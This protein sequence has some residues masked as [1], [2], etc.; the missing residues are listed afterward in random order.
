MIKKQILATVITTMMLG[1]TMGA[2]ARPIN[3]VPLDE[4]MH[5]VQ[6]A[7]LETRDPLSFPRLSA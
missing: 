1:S 2:F 6:E 4:G 3:K 5:V 7:A